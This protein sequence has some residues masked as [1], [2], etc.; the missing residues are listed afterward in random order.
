MH[1][2]AR[3]LK[4]KATPLDKGEFLDE[5]DINPERNVF[6]FHWLILVGLTPKY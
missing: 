1:I 6:F 5:N 3:G 4:F 2:F